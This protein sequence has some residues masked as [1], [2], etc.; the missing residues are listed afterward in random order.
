MALEAK[1]VCQLQ[2]LKNVTLIIFCS[3]KGVFPGYDPPLYTAVE[4]Q[5]SLLWADV[6]IL[7]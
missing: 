7:Q 2:P 5:A 4:V 6:D 1:H 3:L